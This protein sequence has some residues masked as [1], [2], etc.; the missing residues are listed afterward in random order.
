MFDDYVTAIG[1]RNIDGCFRNSRALRILGGLN[2]VRTCPMD[3]LAIEG[4]AGGQAPIGIRYGAEV[5]LTYLMPG[6]TRQRFIDRIR[7]GVSYSRAWFMGR[8]LSLVESEHEKTLR[9]IELLSV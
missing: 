4:D 7:P 2:R 9:E 1:N 6:S 5:L 3:Q 8:A